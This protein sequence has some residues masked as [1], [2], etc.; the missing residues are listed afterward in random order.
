MDAYSS[1]CLF[2]NNL[3]KN[4]ILVEGKLYNPLEK[5]HT[6]PPNVNIE[7]QV[8]HIWKLFPKAVEGSKSN[9]I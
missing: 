5:I 6:I 3:S 7:G 9:L 8:S 2:F 1:Q 4:S